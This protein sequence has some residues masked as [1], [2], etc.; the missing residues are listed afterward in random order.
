M[1]FVL[2][3]FLLLCGSVVF[4]STA[5]GVGLFFLAAGSI[6]TGKAMTDRKYQEKTAAPPPEP[7]PVPQMSEAELRQREREERARQWWEEQ[8]AA[9]ARDAARFVR[10]HF[11]VAGVTFKNDDGSS[12]QKILRGF[13]DK[14]TGISTADCWL[15]EYE[16]EGEPAVRVMTF[17]GCVGNIRR[18]DLSEVREYFD[19][20][21]SRMYLNVETFEDDD[22]RTI[23]RADVCISFARDDPK[24]R[25]YFDAL[26]E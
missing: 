3:I 5:F 17:E 16:Y 6:I 22:D 19:H 14:E 7:Q 24:D 8:K 2:G 4:L 15:E 1:L 20:D 12:R 25:W 26:Q 18:S 23:Y 11:P 9:R 21:V 13:Y 10:K